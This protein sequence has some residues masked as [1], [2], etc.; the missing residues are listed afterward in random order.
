MAK[1]AFDELSLKDLRILQ[2]LLRECSITRAAQVLETTQPVVSKTLAYLRGQ[3]ADLLLVRKGH[4]MQPTAKAVELAPQLRKLLDTAD[5]LQADTQA[6]DPAT[7]DR[8]FGLLVTDVGMVR[9]LPPLLARLA[10]A[11]PRVRIRAVPLGAWQIESKLESGEADLALGS[12]PKAAPHLRRQ[13]L[14]ADGYLSVVRRGVVRMRD[15]RALD[16]F[17]AQRHIL[18][19]ASETGHAAHSQLQRALAAKIAPSNILLHVPSFVAAAVVA[20]QTDGIATLP[21]NLA[22]SITRPLGLD[23]FRPPLTL[24]RIEIA[25]YWHERFH[26]DAAHRWLRAVTFE[27][28]GERQ[29]GASR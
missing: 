7:S 27:L 8:Q 26:R 21:E 10:K 5:D 18:V 19:T 15:M 20:S 3:F 17:A 22:V 29:R 9:F 2:V 6:F 23:S 16:A 28:F 13:R 4:A 11:A 1:S 14:Y 12:F 24:P 25:Q